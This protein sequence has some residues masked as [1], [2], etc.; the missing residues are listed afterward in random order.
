MKLDS[1]LEGEG[2][3]VVEFGLES[4]FRDNPLDEDEVGLESDISISSLSFIP[5]F[6][7]LEAPPGGRVEETG[8]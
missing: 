1:V 6:P 2:V 3:G 7:A 8:M 4:P 5:P